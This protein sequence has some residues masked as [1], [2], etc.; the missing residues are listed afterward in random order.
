MFGKLM[1]YEL[2][3][4][5]RVF[6]PLWGTTLALAMINGFT[7][8]FEPA[9]SAPLLKFILTILP[10]LLLFALGLGM[11]V[12]AFV[13]II[14][15]FYSG[16]LGE[17]GPLAFTLP[18]TFAEQI[19]CRL[20]TAL[21]MVVGCLLTGFLSTVLI[22]LIRGYGDTVQSFFA[23][24]RRVFASYSKT[25]LILFELIV[26]F[27]ASGAYMV[28][29]LYSAIAVGHLVQNHRGLCSLAAFIGIGWIINFI[30]IGMGRLFNRYMETNPL[31]ISVTSFEEALQYL[32][33]FFG[34][35]IGFSLLGCVV[36]WLLTWGILKK[37]LN[38]L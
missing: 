26:F 19:N 30:L 13:L 35:G 4:C 7:M 36:L 17:G 20:L 28:L 3:G 38:I 11:F 8:G 10:G 22:I 1:K 25:G 12:V 23:E 9:I 32:P 24:A 31:V 33:A 5:M 21:I 18:V 6:L 34:I 14:R 29:R 2:R 27:L 15:R 37:R 16:L